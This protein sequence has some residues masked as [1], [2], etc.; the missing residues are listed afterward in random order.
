MNHRF[1]KARNQKHS[2]PKKENEQQRIKW[3]EKYAVYIQAL[4]AIVTLL[5]FWQVIRQN[6]IT[7]RSV[8]LSDSSAMQAKRS[9]DAAQRSVDYADSAYRLTKESFKSSD[10]A[11][12]LSYSLSEK[13][14]QTQMKYADISEL[15]YFTTKKI[16]ER[17]DSNYLKSIG[18]ASNSLDISKESIKLVQ[19]NFEV[20]NKS[21]VL[22]SDIKIDSFAINKQ[23]QITV[24]IKNF[25]KAPA[26]IFYIK[27]GIRLDTSLDPKTLYYEKENIRYFNYFLTTGYDIS[28]P[29]QSFLITPELYITLMKQREYLYVYGEVLYRDNATAK[30]YS[31]V[32]C[33]RILNNRRFAPTPFN[34][35]TYEVK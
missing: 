19:K 18:I 9:A 13:A 32:Y 4:S 8:T 12:K 16:A 29:Y 23:E 6:K 15:N 10:S 3:T 22:F 7:E 35:I 20:E 5:L 34:N 25:G 17:S 28:L 14:L 21:Y 31:Y 2:Y 24:S 27:T 11:G 33:M 26:L 30:M 1:G